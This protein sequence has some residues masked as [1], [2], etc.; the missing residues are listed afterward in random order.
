LHRS[1]E[2]RSGHSAER[3]ATGV[4]PNIECDSISRPTV[5]PQGEPI[6]L[7]L[8]AYR[9]D[10]SRTLGFSTRLESLAAEQGVGVVLTLGEYSRAILHNSLGQYEV[11]LAAAQSA[12]AAGDLSISTWVLPELVEAAARSGHAD[13]AVDAYERLAER[14]RAAGT[15][16]ARGVEAG[17]RA[18]AAD[19]AV[20]EEAYQE[21]LDTLGV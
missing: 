5:G 6:R 1:Y 2:K 17:S 10:E 18:L 8:M 20:A 4:R 16:F 14:T 11:A 21:A 15:D 13:V 19:D 3:R 7:L 12:A 9:G